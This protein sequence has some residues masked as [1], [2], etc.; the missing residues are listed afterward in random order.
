MLYF[1]C[2]ICAPLIVTVSS[3]LC[4]RA[5]EALRDCLPEAL[6]GNTFAEVLQTEEAVQRWLTSLLKNIADGPQYVPSAGQVLP[7]DTTGDPTQ[8]LTFMTSTTGDAA[9]DAAQWAR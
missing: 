9:A 2:C 6:K 7:Q 5:R 3:Y 8:N 1:N 4:C